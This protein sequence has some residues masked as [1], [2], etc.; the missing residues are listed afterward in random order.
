MNDSI[1]MATPRQHLGPTVRALVTTVAVVASMTAHAQSWLDYD[2]VL[3][4]LS[5]LRTSNAAALT[6]YHPTDSSQR[7]LAEGQVGITTGQGHLTAPNQSPH[8]WQALAHVRSIYRMSKRV[9]ARGAM[10]YNNGWGSQAGGSIWVQPDE[11]PFDITETADSTRGN[12]GLERYK[13]QG[14]VGVTTWRGLS[15]GASIGYETAT[16]AKKKDPR[17]TNQHMR[18]DASAGTT[19]QTRGLTLGA[20]YLLRRTTEGVQFRNYGRTDQ[21]YHYLIDQGAAF[22]RNE[23]SGGR[24]YVGTDYE[25]PYLDMRHGIAL[26]AGYA[27]G[28]WSAVVEWQWLHRHGHYGLESPARLDFN[29]H[30]GNEWHLCSWWQHAS[31][32]SIHRVTA[33]WSHQQI[34]DFERTY[35]IISEDG[36]TDTEYYDDRLLGE[37][38]QDDLALTYDLQWGIHRQLAT[39]QAQA[40]VGHQRRDLTASL[41]PYYRQ[42]QT[43]STHITLTGERNWLRDNDHT[44]S[45]RLQAGWATGGG[46]AAKDG[47]YTTPSDGSTAPAEHLLLMMRQYEWLTATRLQGC[48]GLRWSMPLANHR[49]RTYVDVQYGYAHAFDTHYLDNAHRHTAT[50]AIG[51]HF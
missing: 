11:M 45:V 27:H 21:V 32:S 2:Q 3:S 35:R 44:W 9:V 47:T 18:L 22:G 29:R 30:N 38:E 16:Y 48:V 4:P 6:T 41:Y 37:R 12:I 43:H 36:I 23:Q 20:N 46:T 15:M 26:Q 19:W 28:P 17:H 7:L 25:R 24:G 13:L 40:T 10:V 33:S 1:N 34:S 8:S 51:C 14:E 39:W 42:Q 50:L 31:A 5:W 49:L